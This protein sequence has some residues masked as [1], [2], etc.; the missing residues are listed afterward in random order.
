MHTARST[1]SRMASMK[2][3][4]LNNRKNQGISIDSTEIEV[5]MRKKEA[6]VRSVAF[7]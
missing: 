6:L 2:V 3:R 4:W 7:S 1:E 5:I